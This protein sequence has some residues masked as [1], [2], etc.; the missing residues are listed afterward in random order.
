MTAAATHI[1]DYKKRLVDNTIVPV[2]VGAMRL[3]PDGLIVSSALFAAFTLSLP[4]A[5]FSATMMESALVFQFL[6]YCS[7]FLG[8]IPAYNSSTQ[9][10]KCRTG[11]IQP[12]TLLAMSMFSSSAVHSP[13]P[14]APLFMLST[15]SAYIFGTLNAQSKELQA[16]GPAYSSRY[17]MSAVFLSMLLLIF[18]GFR[19][20][21]ECDTPAVAILTVPVGLILGFVLVWQNKSLFGDTSINLLGIPQL[22]NRAASGEQIYICPK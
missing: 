13:F 22:Y 19:V 4:F 2:V 18:I 15:A 3:F 5:V 12:N 16:L 21:Y 11:F 14:S 20:L 17:Y 10:A 6:Q 8:L 7:T 1:V 9:N